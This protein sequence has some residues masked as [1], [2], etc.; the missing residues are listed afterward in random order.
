LKKLLLRRPHKG[1]VKKE[2][3]EIMGQLYNK[4][5]L[6]QKRRQL[7]NNK[8]DAEKY[9]W[10]ELKGRQLADR[11]FRRQHSVGN[12]ILDFYCTEEKLAIELDGEHHYEE[13]QMAYDLER[14]KYLQSLGINVL[15]FKNGDVL[16]DRDKVVKEIENFIRKQN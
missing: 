9:L 7:R 14:T 8:T 1:V 11:K 5:S 4:K 13:E 12:Y 15:R 16:F 6:N 2:R 10:Y 3:K